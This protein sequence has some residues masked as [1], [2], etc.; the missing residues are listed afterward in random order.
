MLAHLSKP[1][2][3][4]GISY[5]YGS[6]IHDSTSTPVEN[7][8]SGPNHMADITVQHLQRVSHNLIVFS[9]YC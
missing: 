8:D 2:L 9:S 7:L 3:T 6:K 4:S 5:K 1:L